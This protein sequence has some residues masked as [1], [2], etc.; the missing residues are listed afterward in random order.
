MGERFQKRCNEP[1]CVLRTAHRSG[2]CE[3]HQKDNTRKRQRAIYDRERH[4]DAVSKGY[5]ATW[6]K[7]KTML[8]GRG[9]VICQKIENGKQCTRP[10]EIFHHIISPR[11]NPALMYDPRNIVGV[12][13]QHHPPTEGEP[14]ENLP[15]L[16]EIY[17]PT[18]WSD[19]IVG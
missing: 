4:Q 2:Y 3:Q 15:R 8:R 16:R 10:V 18:I 7:I 19:P 9:N 11:E 14:K 17:V 6:G 1:G 13:R 5:N 12:C